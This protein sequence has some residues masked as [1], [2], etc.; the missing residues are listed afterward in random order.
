[1]QPAITG[2]DERLDAVLAELQALRAML[3]RLV[4]MP[5]PQRDPHAPVPLRQPVR[6][7]KKS[8]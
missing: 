6:R 8:P 2:T 4:P 1:M 5:A 3:E 7:G